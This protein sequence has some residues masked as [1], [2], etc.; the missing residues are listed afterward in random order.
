MSKIL[1]KI[2]EKSA[3]FAFGTVFLVLFGDR[4]SLFF[5]E[6]SYIYSFFSSRKQ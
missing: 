5:D 1:R 2:Y 3:A 4:K 6:K